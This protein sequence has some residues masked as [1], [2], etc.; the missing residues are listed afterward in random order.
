MKHAHLTTAI[1]VAAIASTA[2]A[3]GFFSEVE[4]NDTLILANDIGVFDAPGGSMLI[5]GVLEDGDVD[6]FEFTLSDEA[7]FSVFALFSASDSDGIMQLVAEG[8]DVIAFDDDSGIDLMPAIQMADLSAGKYFIGISGFGDVDSSSV[9]T[10]ELADGHLDT[11]ETHGESF[12]YKL[13][14]GFTIVPA[15]GSL[16]LCGIGGVM[17]T[18]RKRYTA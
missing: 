6:W 1:G 2:Y 7:S 11:G 4:D 9:D 8:G 3:G 12:G 5:D 17:M 16:A 18:R 10:D 15:P 13:N 14:I